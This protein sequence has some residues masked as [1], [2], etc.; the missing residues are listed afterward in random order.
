V[1]GL[2]A[3]QRISS[4]FQHNGNFLFEK[5]ITHGFVHSLL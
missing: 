3:E 5:E 1:D 4:I 2:I